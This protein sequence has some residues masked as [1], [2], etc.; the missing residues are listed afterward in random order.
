MLC[1]LGFYNTLEILK[2]GGGVC[3]A[4]QVTSVGGGGQNNPLV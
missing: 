2:R 3:L 1:A 4:P